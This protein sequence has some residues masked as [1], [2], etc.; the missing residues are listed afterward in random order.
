MKWEN[1]PYKD[2]KYIIFDDLMNGLS[3]PE[4]HCFAIKISDISNAID[5]MFQKLLSNPPLD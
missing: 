3:E 4:Y 2:L 5:E 1:D